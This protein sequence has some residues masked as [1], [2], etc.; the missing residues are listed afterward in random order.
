MQQSVVGNKK[1]SKPTPGQAVPDLIPIKE[2]ARDP[3][4]VYYGTKFS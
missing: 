3:S 2:I 1:P 4:G